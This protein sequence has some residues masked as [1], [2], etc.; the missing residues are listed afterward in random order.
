MISH[1]RSLHVDPIAPA[2]TPSLF[3]V[4]IISID[5]TLRRHIVAAA[6]PE[7]AEALAYAG[8]AIEIIDGIVIE[9]LK[10]TTD[11]ITVFP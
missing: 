10:K 4:T 3:A 1:P 2:P 11:S 8:R 9:Q 6:T 7:E 5:V